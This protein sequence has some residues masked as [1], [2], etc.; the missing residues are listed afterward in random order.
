MLRRCSKGMKRCSRNENHSWHLLALK[1]KIY[2]SSYDGLKYEVA[3]VVGHCRGYIV[4]SYL[5]SILLNA[6]HQFPDS[7]QLLKIEFEEMA[8][9]HTCQDTFN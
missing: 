7:Y 2:S 4:V 6:Y 8:K 9:G 5:F 3:G 1:A